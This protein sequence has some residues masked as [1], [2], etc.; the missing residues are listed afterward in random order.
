MRRPIFVA[1]ISMSQS[2]INID[3]YRYELPVDRIAFH[4]L[5][6][7]DQSQLLV[8]REGS[9]QHSKFSKLSEWIP[10]RCLMIF[11]NTSVIQARLHFKKETGADIEIFLLNPVAPSVLVHEAMATDR[12]VRWHCTI[13]NKKRWTQGKLLHLQAPTFKLEAQLVDPYNDI[14]EFASYPPQPFAVAID[15]LGATPLPPYIKRSPEQTDRERYQTVYSSAPGAVAAPT[16]G[17]HFTDNVLKELRSR[18]VQIDF[19]T[20]HVSAGTFQPVKVQ[21][22]LEHDMH[23]EQILVYADTIQLLLQDLPVCAVGTT[24]LRSLESIYWYGVKLENDPK[25]EFIIAKLDPY[26]LLAIPRKRALENVARRLTRNRSN[27]LTGNTSIY[28]FPGYDFKIVDALITNFHQPGSTLLLLIAA[29]IGNDWKL[30]YNEALKAGY[31]FLSYGDSSL[32][33]RPGASF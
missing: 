27:Q 14:V 21:N 9:I 26:N 24:S 15:A 31:R 7:R 10:S 23:A 18:G 1:I 4:P 12:P 11:N 32:L 13:G 20:L 25:A 8:Y 3:D 16:A 28:I 19:L 5:A 17:L 22:A 6:D 29:F 33:I 2:A 30:V